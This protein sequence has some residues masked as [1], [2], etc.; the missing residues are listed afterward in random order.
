[1]QELDTV[2]ELSR[3]QFAAT[4][5]YH[6]LFVPLTLG[7][8][9]LLATMETIY[10]IT[11]RDIY[12]QMTH[13]WSKLFAI[14]FALGVATG[15][16]MEF[17]FGTNWSTYS[18]FVGDIFGA[19]LAIE[20]LMAFFLES[21]FVG[22]MLFGWGKLSRG[23]HLL[24]TYMVALGSNLSA[25][26]ILVA[27]GYMQNPVGSVFNPDTMR[28]E[29]TS[30]PDLIFSPEAQA[31]FV[32]TSIAGYVT[33]AIF[34]V[35]ISAFYLLRRRH[36]E[37]AKRSF[38]VAALF[39]VFATVGVISLGD[40]LGFING[41]AQPTK[42]A[43]M[44]GLWETAEAPAGFNL[45]AWPNQEEKRND[46]E[47]Q[48]P[49]LLTP[50]V[51]HTFDESIP[52]VNDLEADAETKIRDGIP[53][54]IALQTLR[55]NPDD[56][57]AR[58]T[59]DAHQDNLG[60]ALLVQRYAED[61]SQATDAQI[62]KAA[63]DTIPP[64]ATVFWSFRVMVVTA[65]LMMAFL[66]L[67]VIYSLRGTLHRHNWFLRLAP[68]MIP[69]PFIANEAGWIVAELGRQP[70]TVYGQLPTWLSAST[71]SVGYMVFSLIGFVLL[72]TLFIVIEMFLMVK[73]IRLGP[74]EGKHESPAEP[75]SQRH[76]SQW[77]E[78]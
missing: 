66:I 15:L 21:T 75:T 36:I 47:V 50:L 77:S 8:S 63:A 55:E 26:W 78:A 2:I 35:G 33:A 56:A 51:T 69:V 49:Y 74:S 27:N 53:A 16:T 61:V 22:L 19:P 39:G 43:A 11:G 7:L 54:L 46:F 24:V 71:H 70:W 58:A 52:G 32:H 20:G 59:F 31:K 41:S 23:K 5:L 14:N 42:L 64:V 73:F 37:L 38:R 65:F 34:V 1:M 12:R 44:E 57:E 67:A 3:L 28:M 72:Y 6:Y 4:A 60:Y 40:A 30:L 25:L 18:H 68:W 62:A 48:V 9:V 10:V 76:S 29:L 13:F 17:E 45:I